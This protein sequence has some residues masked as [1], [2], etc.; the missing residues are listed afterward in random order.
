MRALPR[1]S[2]LDQ[3]DRKF[4]VG[5]FQSDL[6]NAD[7]AHPGEV[8]RRNLDLFD[9]VLIMDG[10]ELGKP[11]NVAVK[12]VG[13]G[14]SAARAARTGKSL[15]VGRRYLLALFVGAGDP[16][17]G[18]QIKETRHRLVGLPGDDLPLFIDETH[19]ALPAC[20]V[21]Q[22]EIFEFGKT[23]AIRAFEQSASP[24]IG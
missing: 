1:R 9:R 13:F 12:D 14:P 5:E 4:R 24:A 19:G 6:G 22:R 17:D 16:R 21:G 3:R 11:E 2:A 10:S 15:Y 18:L 7:A 20:I 23:I 8:Q